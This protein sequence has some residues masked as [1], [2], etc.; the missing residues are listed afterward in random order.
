L[1]A[2]GYPADDVTT[3]LTRNIAAR[4]LPAGNWHPAGARPPMEYSD[5]PATAFAVRAMRLYGARARAPEYE[6]RIGRARRW[7][8]GV[9][10]RSTDERVFQLLG[11][12]WAKSDAPMLTKLAA[13]LLAEQCRDGGWAQLATLSSDAYATGLVLYALNQAGGLSTSDPAYLRGVKYLRQTQMPDGSWLVE[14]H[15]IAIQPELDAKFPHGRN[16]F[17]SAAGTSWAATALML[18]ARPQNR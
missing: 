11:L 3:A 2:A 15:A 17:I 6:T 10:P 5:V 7:L 8:L 1:A 12:A 18:T 9:Q 4:Q 14:T 13:A 16:Q